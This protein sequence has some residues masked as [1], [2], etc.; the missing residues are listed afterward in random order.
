MALGEYINET[1]AEIKHVSWPTTRQ[2]ISYTIVVIVISLITAFYLGA[3]DFAFSFV[4]D[5]IVTR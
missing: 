2:I 3:L 4:L 5:K 1:R